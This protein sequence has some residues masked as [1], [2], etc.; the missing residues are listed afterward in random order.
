MSAEYEERVENELDALY[1][2]ALF[3]TAGNE[4]DAEWLLL[5]TV[6]GDQ[7]GDDG[8]AGSARWFEARLAQLFLGSTVAP[9]PASPEWTDVA[10]IPALGRE[11]LFRASAAVPT[12]ARA[13]LW[14]VLLRGWSYR[15]ASAALGVS[16]ETLRR[17]LDYRHLL[18]QEILRRDRPL[19]SA[20]GT[21]T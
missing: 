10:P 21:V 16:I 4:Q 20:E 17:M 5:D 11:D 1:R 12:W 7:A 9:A 18:V 15:D 2:G 6:G 13:A 3:L 14:L 8:D 19:R